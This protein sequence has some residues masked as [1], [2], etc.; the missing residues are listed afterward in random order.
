MALDDIYVDPLVFP[1][2]TD[3][4]SALATIAAIGA[5]MARYPGVHTICGLT[6]VSHGLPARK[7]VNRTFLV[8]A[9]SRGMD[10]AI[11]DPTDRDSCRR[12]PPPAPCSAATTTAWT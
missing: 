8:G 6:N 2:G 7:L 10:A 12:W 5:I 1:L 4:Q 9:M 3:S 11:L